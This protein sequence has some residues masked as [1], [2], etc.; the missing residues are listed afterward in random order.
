MMTL[1]RQ[2]AKSKCKSLGNEQK[3]EATLDELEK[4]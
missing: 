1:K 3:L 4:A 2:V